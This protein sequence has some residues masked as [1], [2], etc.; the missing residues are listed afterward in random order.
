MHSAEQV[1]FH[2]PIAG[3]T[4]RILAYLVDF[5]LIWILIFGVLLMVAVVAPALY[6]FLA[7]LGEII[8]R[9]DP[10]AGPAEIESAMGPLL[11]VFLLVLVT[12]EMIYFI[13]WET[14]S[15]GRS[16]GKALVGLRVTGDGGQPLTLRASAVRNLL[17][18]V[19]MLPANY[20][21]GLIAIVVSP[22]GK[23]LGDLAAGTIVV[24]VDRV[25]SVAELDLGEE[26]GEGFRFDRSQIERVGAAERK[27][28]RQTL[29][30]L[31][32]LKADKRDEVLERSVEALRQRLG[33]ED[34][35]APAERAAFLAALFRAVAP[36]R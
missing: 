19:D 21:T 18:I 17:R 4:S 16:P 14:F 28:L 33:I 35:I 3:P 23:R 5:I 8:E 15:G 10:E 6:S 31:R 12:G 11:A 13:L 30:R 2:L 36:R 26:A 7:P 22:E 9:I 27:L 34:E 20:L 24:R 1:A 32:T 25:P 29:R